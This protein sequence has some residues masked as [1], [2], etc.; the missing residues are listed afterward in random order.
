[1]AGVDNVSTPLY[2]RKI[3]LAKINDYV[4]PMCQRLDVHAALCIQTEII[5]CVGLIVLQF[6]FDI[7][8]W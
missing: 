7:I 4:D 2:T 5:S 1:M 6:E 3:D 8:C